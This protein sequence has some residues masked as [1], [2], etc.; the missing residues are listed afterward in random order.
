MSLNVVI[1]KGPAGFATAQ[2]LS[3][4]GHQV[5]VV[6]R[7]GRPPSFDS[8]WST[9]EA[10]VR[11][12]ELDVTRGSD[13]AA[14]ARGALAIYNCASPAYAHWVTELPPLT[15]ALLHAAERTGSL[16]VNLSNLYPY[17]NPG[18]DLDESF[19]D[20]PEGP[21][22]WARAAMWA[23]IRERHRAGALQGVE[24]RAAD[25]VGPRVGKNGH[26]G[27]RVVP[28]LLAG[29]RLKFVLNP[30]A[31]RSWTAVSDLGEAL[32]RASRTPETWGSA[33]VAP[34]IG[35]LSAREAVQIMSREA[36]V[37]VPPIG[38]VP[39]AVLRM[40]GTVNREAREL[41][42]IRYQLDGRYVARSDAFES[43]TGFRSASA[44]A[45]LGETVRW[46]KM[47]AA[48]GRRAA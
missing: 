17:G 37:A 20:V 38:R 19:L 23:A 34:V 8:D 18:G 40:A 2:A 48:P 47:R 6:S 31:Q 22:G 29:K 24:L 21:K 33:W 12:E 11:H 42:E 27:E 13:L 32:E 9:L 15:N 44:R 43:L 28:P 25:F 30:D 7:T 45:V 26:L 46:W 36:G 3:S 5:I 10:T 35:P 4:K 39:W 41:Q 14:L 16:L 1:G